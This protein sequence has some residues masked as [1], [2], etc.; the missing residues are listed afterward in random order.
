MFRPAFSTLLLCV[1]YSIFQ[2]G[3]LDNGLARLPAMGYNTW[4]DFRCEI[5]EEDVM[6]VIDAFVSLDMKSYG[7]QYINMDDCWANDV[8][9]MGRWPNGTIRYNTTRFPSGIRP[10]ADYAHAKGYKLGIYTD[11][12]NATC[13]HKVSICGSSFAT[14]DLNSARAF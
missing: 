4:N 10:L 8:G 12:G 2:V 6:N 1:V 3:A 14:E 7:Y 5:T 13:A 11:R 9:P